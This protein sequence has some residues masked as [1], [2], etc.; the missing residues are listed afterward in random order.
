MLIGEMDFSRI[1]RLMLEKVE[2]QIQGACVD[3]YVGKPLRKGNNR[4]QFAPD[5]S[6]WIGQTDHGWVGDQGI[7]RISW[8]GKVPME[9]LAMNVT[10]QGFDLTFTHPVDKSVAGIARNTSLNAITILTTKNMALSKWI[11]S[12]YK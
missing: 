4:L 8:N 11:C 5:G 3:L 7:Q 2:G 10:S 6:L 9:I 1:M 12:R